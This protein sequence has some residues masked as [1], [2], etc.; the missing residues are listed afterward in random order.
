MRKAFQYPIASLPQLNGVT[1]SF[2][3][4]GGVVFSLFIGHDFQLVFRDFTRYDKINDLVLGHTH[5]LILA[6]R[7]QGLPIHLNCLPGFFFL[8]PDLDFLSWF[9][10]WGGVMLGFLLFLPNRSN[11]SSRRVSAS[12][13]KVANSAA[14]FFLFLS[15]DWCDVYVIDLHRSSFLFLWDKH[16]PYFFSRESQVIGLLYSDIHLFCQGSWFI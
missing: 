1:D 14:I 11:I 13:N 15:N 10:Y 12:K 2:S 4:L 5:F 7:R 8:S 16:N 9:W 6:S 3:G